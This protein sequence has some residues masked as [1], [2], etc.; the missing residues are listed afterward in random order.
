[1]EQVTIP[2]TDLQISAMCMGTIGFGT[3]VRGRDTDRLVA[4][5][6]E[7]GGC[8]FDTAHCY[9]FWMEDGLGAS[10]R[11]LGASLRRLG[12]WGK[13]VVATKGGHPDAGPKYRR[14][15]DYMSES[16]IRSDLDESLERL[17]TE[18]ID[19]YYLHRDDPRMPVDKVIDI[20][21]REIERGRIRSI[22]ASNW[23]VERMSAANLYAARAGRQGFVASELQWSLAQPNWQVGPDPTTRFVTPEIAL[24][25]TEANLPLV[26]Y[27]A[28]GSGYFSGAAK[29]P[30]TYD[31]PTNRARRKR[32]QELAKQVGC[33]PVQVALAYLLHQPGRVIPLFGT[34]DPAHLTEI[35]GANEVSLAPEQ[36]AWLQEG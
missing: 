14:P 4:A 8:F 20:L 16:M 22:G 29:N 10:E 21:N 5:F 15:D 36:V 1:M 13:V 9:A 19:L 24:W 25:H 32:A 34:T 33:T 28:T 11:E 35:L 17:G 12:C 23:S 7:A 3:T 31:N 26:A 2:G 27:S 30:S 18:R 6:I